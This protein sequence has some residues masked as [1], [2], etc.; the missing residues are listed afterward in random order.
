MLN[1]KFF[2]TLKDVWSNF[3]KGSHAYQQSRKNQLLKKA[4]K[5]WNKTQFE[6]S[7]QRI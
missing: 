4:I 3:I 6:Q 5:N 1:S 2:N 7:R